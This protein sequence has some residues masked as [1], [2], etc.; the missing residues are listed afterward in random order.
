M[1]SLTWMTAALAVDAYGAAISEEPLSV[2]LIAAYI[3]AGLIGGGAAW[4]V[5]PILLARL[6]VSLAG[7]NSEKDAIARLESQWV[8]AI[9]E[10]DAARRAANE[11]YRERNDILRELAQVQAQLAGLTERC[12]L[13]AETIERQNKLIERQSERVEALTVQVVQLKESIHGKEG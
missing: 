6:A 5:L 11:A 13:Q 2:P 4:K 1:T 12:K 8:A 3:L 7:A 9:A 10:A